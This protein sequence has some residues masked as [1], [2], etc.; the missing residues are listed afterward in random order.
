MGKSLEE[1]TVLALGSFGLKDH[2]VPILDRILS[3]LDHRGGGDPIRDAMIP[4]QRKASLHAPDQR[5]E[6]SQGGLQR[7]T[8]Q[9]EPKR[10]ARRVGDRWKDVGIDDALDH[11]HVSERRS[12]SIYETRVH[13][14]IGR[15][16]RPLHQAKDRVVGL[17]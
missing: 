1:T 7:W 4:R 9:V 6:I 3:V 17:E 15:L 16:T 14:R 10:Q 5:H 13:R 12:I 8:D 11:Q 2:L